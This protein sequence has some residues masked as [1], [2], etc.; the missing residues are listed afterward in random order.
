MLTP[1]HSDYDR[2]GDTEAF[3]IFPD[4]Q[5]QLSKFASVQD[6]LREW[7]PSVARRIEHFA[8]IT[9]A[10]LDIDGFRIDKATQITPDMLGYWSDS[11]RQCA[12]K[13]GK[14]NFF[15]PGEITGGDTF[16]AIYL[17]RGRQPNM[18]P[19][20]VQGAFSLTS[21]SDD[22]YFIREK[23][24]NALDAGAFHYSVYRSM[25]RFMGMDGNLTAGFDTPGNWVDMWNTM[26]VSND[27][28]NANTGQLDPR[29]MYGV[30]NQDVFRWPAIKDGEKKMLLGLF[31]TTLVMPGIPKVRLPR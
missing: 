1:A 22:E 20:D 4:W 23:R 11:V 26:A 7:K 15:I 12:R 13:F 29:H 2:Y 24:K 3:G 17:G 5:R 28:V 14:E 10:I 6:R 18:R 9:I 19:S 31:I 21:D 27:L 25:I 30:T 16:G 8:C